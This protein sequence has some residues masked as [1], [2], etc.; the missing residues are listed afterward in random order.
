MKYRTVNGTFVKLRHRLGWEGNG[1]RRPPRL[2]DLRHSFAC[3]CLLAWYR[4]GGDINVKLPALSTYLGHAGVTHTYWY[5]TAVPDLMAVA[6][7]RF[8]Q[9]AGEF[10]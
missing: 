2:Q 3:R 1:T 7:T 9:Q 5:L 4:E 6:S 10:Q 8:E